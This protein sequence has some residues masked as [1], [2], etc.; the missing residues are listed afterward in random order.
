MSRHLTTAERLE[1]AV[2]EADLQAQV[3]ELAAL[4]GWRVFHDH[5]SRRNHA[6]FPDLVLVRRS[7]LVF[8]ELK[9]RTGRVRPAQ[10]EWLAAL[11]AVADEARGHVTVH[12]WRPGDWPDIERVLR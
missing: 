11:E 4:R 7:R 8:A 12:L 1:D 3:L 10:Q 5:D 9:T 2:T 6:G